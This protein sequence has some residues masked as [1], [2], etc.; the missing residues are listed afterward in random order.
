MRPSSASAVRG[1]ECG[2]GTECAP[3]LRLGRSPEVH[4]GIAAPRRPRGG[5]RLER[6]CFAGESQPDGTLAVVG[7][8][9][10]IEKQISTDEII[11]ATEFRWVPSLE[12]VKARA[13]R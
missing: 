2:R 1:T 10:R 4:S 5:S 13:A 3:I 12:R 6:A 11:V 7:D 8:F 9:A